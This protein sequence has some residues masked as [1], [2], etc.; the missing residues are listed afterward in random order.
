[1]KSIKDFSDTDLMNALRDRGY[2]LSIWDKTDILHQAEKLD[3]ELSEEEALQ[4]L[5]DIDNDHDATV[6][7]N[8]DVISFHLHEIQAPHK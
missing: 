5:Y 8:W 6:G 4:V 7:I 2:A 1:M 3:I